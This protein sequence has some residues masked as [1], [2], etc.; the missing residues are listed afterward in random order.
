MV[1]E[2][3]ILMLQGFDAEELCRNVERFGVTTIMLAPPILLTLSLHPG[4][5]SVLILFSVL[6]LLACVPPADDGW[7][8]FFGGGAA[9][10]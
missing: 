10:L 1:G 5:L 6:S 3:C 2:P 9:L 4:E 7:V 8:F